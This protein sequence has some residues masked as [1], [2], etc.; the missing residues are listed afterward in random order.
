MARF[1]T[2]MDGQSKFQPLLDVT[3]VGIPNG[4]VTPRSRLP[5]QM[6]LC[7]HWSEKTVEDVRFSYHRSENERDTHLA[8]GRPWLLK[9]QPHNP[10]RAQSQLFCEWTVFKQDKQLPLPTCY[11]YFARS[12]AGKMVE[13]MLM[14]RVAFSL[15]DAFT[16]LRSTTQPTP[17]SVT[18]VKRLLQN[19]IHEMIRLC[20]DEGYRLHDWH[21]ENIAF[22]DTSQARV[23]LVDWTQNELVKGTPAKHMMKNA[24]LQFIRFLNYFPDS[25]AKKCQDRSS[26][27]AWQDIMK[28]VKEKIQS[29]WKSLWSLPDS[30]DLRR[31]DDLLT[32][33][34]PE[35]RRVDT[36]RR[37]IAVEVSLATPAQCPKSLPMTSVRIPTEPA[38][39]SLGYSEPGRVTMAPLTIDAATLNS[40]VPSTSCSSSSARPTVCASSLGNSEPGRVTE[41]PLTIDVA[42]LSSQAASTICPSSRPTLCPSSKPSTL[43]PPPPPR[44]GRAENGN[45]CPTLRPRTPDGFEE[46]D[47]IVASLTFPG[48]HGAAARSLCKDAVEELLATLRG[49]GAK[50]GKES[51]DHMYMQDRKAANP[52]L[53]HVHKPNRYDETTGNALSLLFGCLL[54]QI[55]EMGFHS[56]MSHVPKAARDVK[57]FHKDQ[58][59]PFA[60][61]CRPPWLQMVHAQKFQRLNNWLLKKLTLDPEALVMLPPPMKIYKKC[62]LCWNTFW[63]TA[64]ERDEL[65]VRVMRAYTCGGQRLLANGVDLAMT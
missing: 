3:L 53:Y 49:Q 43:A 16:K 17:L 52:P 22:E 62:D 26:C 64:T 5:Q 10:S 7:L 14:D 61:G 11:G 29:W 18:V 1:V 65:V 32:K 47:A 58:A 9:S 31:L 60:E 55:E 56:R 20:R 21:T 23:V 54:E 35:A 51:A 38:Q 40:Q 44:L 15:Q 45:E 50:H 19:S 24:M 25:V 41:A 48:S 4:A 12:I 57:K 28:D 36:G 42:T 27:A 34:I 39:S 8:E 2:T 63:L 59:A 13:L 46:T 33:M 6:L 30:H 37:E